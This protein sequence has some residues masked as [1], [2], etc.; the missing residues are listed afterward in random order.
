MKDL[1]QILNLPPTATPEDIRR[2]FRKLAL[3]YHP[4][5]NDDPAAVKQ[6]TEIQEAYAVLRDPVKRASYNCQRYR[7]DPSHRKK[8]RPANT[9]EVLLMAG[10]F[11]DRARHIDPFRLDMDRLAFELTAILSPGNIALF[12]QPG[13]QAAQHLLLQHLQPALR[14]LPL[15][16]V[17]E[18]LAPMQL[19]T[20]GN[21]LLAAEVNTL[22][23]EIR[24][25][26]HWNRYKIWI[27]LVI[28]IL[29]CML[30]YLAGKR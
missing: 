26:Y 8:T 13:K 23:K 2:A 28:T 9:E 1:Y 29:F 22:L 18:I 5:K 10:K 30:I 27:A 15:P 24:W 12:D 19:L 20:A 14:L 3:Q 7:A 25:T 4:D 17:R 6:F 21:Q 16:M 11:S